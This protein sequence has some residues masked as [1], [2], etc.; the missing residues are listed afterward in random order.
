MELRRF[1][2]I[3]ISHAWHSEFKAVKVQIDFTYVITH[4]RRA[5]FDTH[6]P[7]ILVAD[8]P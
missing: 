6:L 4:R 2:H 3:T 8:R 7:D 1:R 5:F